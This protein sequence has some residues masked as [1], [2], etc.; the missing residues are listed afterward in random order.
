ME[1]AS[2]FLR[3]STDQDDFIDS[4]GSIESLIFSLLY[5]EFFTVKRVLPRFRGQVS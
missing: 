4:I 1:V 2:R 5:H 3:F